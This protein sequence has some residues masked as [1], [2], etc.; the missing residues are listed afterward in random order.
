[1]LRTCSQQRLQLG[2][3]GTLYVW[4]LGRHEFGPYMLSLEVWFWSFD[5]QIHID[6]FRFS[7]T[8]PDLLSSTFSTGAGM[9]QRNVPVLDRL[10]SSISTS[11]LGHGI[12]RRPACLADGLVLVRCSV[13]SDASHCSHRTATSNKTF[14]LTINFI[15]VHFTLARSPLKGTYPLHPR[16]VGYY[17]PST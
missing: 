10:L 11:L 4:K 7:Q 9:G 2:L 12:A 13:P 15:H 5:F 17:V 3:S 14:A 1:M 6:T 16:R 8:S